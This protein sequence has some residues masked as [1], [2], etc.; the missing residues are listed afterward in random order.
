MHVYM[1]MCEYAY[2][3]VHVCVYGAQIHFA[4]AWAM[5]YAINHDIPPV[6]V[7]EVMSRQHLASPSSSFA[8]QIHG[9]TWSYFQHLRK[10]KS[11]TAVWTDLCKVSPHGLEPGWSV[12]YSHLGLLARPLSTTASVRVHVRTGARLRRLL[13]RQAHIAPPLV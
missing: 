10:D 9:S 5:E 4:A 13:Q 11:P 2:A 7:L 1:H 8:G 3:H 12:L 6:H